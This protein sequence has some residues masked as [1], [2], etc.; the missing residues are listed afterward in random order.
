MTPKEDV[1]AMCLLI[2]SAMNKIPFSLDSQIC[3]VQVRKSIL[4]PFELGARNAK[5]FVC[6]PQGYPQARRKRGLGGVT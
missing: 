6:A 2:A 4:Y 5:Q 1:I 3:L